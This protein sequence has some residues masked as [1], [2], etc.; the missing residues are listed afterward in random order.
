[1]S[2]GRLY[3]ESYLEETCATGI[4]SSHIE[5]PADLTPHVGV[6]GHVSIVEITG[7]MLLGKQC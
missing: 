7:F 5:S 2:G 6:M 1:M 3:R 4:G